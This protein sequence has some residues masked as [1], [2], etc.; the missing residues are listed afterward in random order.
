MSSF[1]YYE[2]DMCGEHIKFGILDGTEYIWQEMHFCGKC[3]KRIK[4]LRSEH[5]K[6]I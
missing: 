2:C 4:M 1:K 3:K 6:R 5:D